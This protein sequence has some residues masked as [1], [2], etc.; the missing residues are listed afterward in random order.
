MIQA[1]LTV[2][3]GTLLYLGF[4]A[5]VTHIRH[6]FTQISGVLLAY[7]DNRDR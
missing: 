2:I 6:P 1:I 4:S 3:F 7:T 5:L